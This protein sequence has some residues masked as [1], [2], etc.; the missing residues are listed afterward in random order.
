MGKGRGACVGV[1]YSSE[2]CGGQDGTASPAPRRHDPPVMDESGEIH[3]GTL[4]RAHFWPVLQKF[5]RVKTKSKSPR[6]V[7]HLDYNLAAFV[8]PT[9]LGYNFKMPSSRPDFKRKCI[10]MELDDAPTSF[11]QEINIRDEQWLEISRREEEKTAVPSSQQGGTTTQA[12][13]PND[14]SR[15]EAETPRLVYLGLSFWLSFSFACAFPDPTLL[16]DA[17]GVLPSGS[18][19]PRVACLI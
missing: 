14:E 6:A 2:G 1:V 18:P 11:W 15:K 8:C 10:E 16:E 5:T 4:Y 12:A 17:S 13:K 7:S 3:C 19:H 9:F